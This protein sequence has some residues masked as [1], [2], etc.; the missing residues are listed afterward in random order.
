MLHA[1]ELG[2][3][4][5]VCARIG[6][7]SAVEHE[8]NG[9]PY[10]VRFTESEAFPVTVALLEVPEHHYFLAEDRAWIVAF[11]FEGDLDVVDA[12]GTWPGL[13]AG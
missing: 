5:D 2:L 11:S 10:G 6:P 3:R 8:G 1:E 12:T 4:G 13:P 9:S 7:G